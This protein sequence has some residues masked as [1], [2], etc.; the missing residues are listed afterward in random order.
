MCPQFYRVEVKVLPPEADA[1]PRTRSVLRR[2][3]HFT[4][5]YAKVSRHISTSLVPVQHA[6][7]CIV[8]PQQGCKVVTYPNLTLRRVQC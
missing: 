2:F 8:D 4:K 6:E 5:L 3:S 7:A 1:A